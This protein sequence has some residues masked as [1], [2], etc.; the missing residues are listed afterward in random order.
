LR[1]LLISR[2]L[3]HASSS[4]ASRLDGL[5]SPQAQASGNA[6]QALVV[7]VEMSVQAAAMV[8]AEAMALAAAMAASNAMATAATMAV[9]AAMVTAS[10]SCVER[11]CG[12]NAVSGAMTVASMTAGKAAA[13]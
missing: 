11:I 6:E 8:T 12:V 10:D 1:P 7:V 9:A 5:S 3:Y 4:K 13:R 2:T